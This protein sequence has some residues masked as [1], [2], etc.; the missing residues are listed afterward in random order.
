MD[1]WVSNEVG[2]TST[3]G[4]VGSTQR[5]QYQLI[6]HL[7]VIFLKPGLPSRALTRLNFGKNFPSAEAP[8][9]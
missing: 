7:L 3:F 6:L 8:P 5:M 1:L 9:H 4:V 2:T